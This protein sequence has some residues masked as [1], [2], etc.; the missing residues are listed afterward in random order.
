M[1]W[2]SLRWLWVSLVVTVALA[3][4]L[5][6]AGGWR[7]G[8]VFAL[9][10]LLPGIAWR[11]RLP[12]RRWMSGL[13]L[14]L[15]LVTWLTLL[16]VYLPGPLSRAA[17]AAGAALLALLPLALPAGEQER[18]PAP[19]DR[20]LLLAVAAVLL[21]AAL[22]RLPNMGA[23][24]LQGDE[25]IV[26]QRAA[27]AMLGDDAQL[28]RHQKGPV[29]ILI[30]LA[31]WRLNGLLDETTARLPFTLAGLLVIPALMLAA[32]GWLP[33][34]AAV[35]A[36]LFLALNGFGVAFARIVQYQSFV[37]LWGVLALYHA[38][39]Y[40]QGRLPGDLLLA[41]AFLGGG[42][43]AHYDAILLAPAVAW[44]V[45]PVLFRQG[46][47][48]W[49]AWAT[50]LL[51][52]AL[53][54]GSF[55]LPYALS[56]TFGGTSSYLLEDRLGNG[57][58]W[59]GGRVW[60]M[61]TLYNDT[62]M[63]VALLLLAAVGLWAL[64]REPAALLLFAVPALFYTVVV[65]DPRTHIYTAAP[66]LALLAAAGGLAL[67]RAQRTLAA[68]LLALLAASSTLYLA[69]IF[70]DPTPERQRTWAE[71]APPF[72]L[73]TWDAPPEYGLFGFPHQA[74]WRL[75][76][77]RV[78]AFPYASNEEEEITAWYM[79]QAPRTY[80]PDLATFLRA[81]R[82]QDALPIP[83]EMVEGLHL[84]ETILVNGEPSLAIFGREPAGTPRQSE[85]AGVRLWRAPEEVVPRS[86]EPEHPLD[87]TLGDRVRLLGY[88]LDS[89]AAHPGGSLGVTLYWQALAPFER[90]YQVFVHLYDGQMRAQDDGAPRCDTHPTTHWEP[91]DI[92][93]DPRRLAL[94]ADLPPG[95]YPLLAGMYDLLEGTRLPIA[96]TEGDALP[97][98][99]VTIRDEAQ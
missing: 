82:A 54:A 11:T 95:S 84:Q 35:V 31:T 29:E 72:Y 22:L 46:R 9:L 93:A 12:G 87:V 74:G 56:P 80:C 17:L 40:R 92:I 94:P 34:G 68:L 57:L 91:V 52:G 15:L 64:R 32:R 3:S 89:S 16:L 77:R 39:R 27:A 48:V 4:V 61:A 51:A 71:N 33:A 79:A 10:W 63:V 25:G 65:V 85:A 81:E 60:Q 42:L 24:E 13:G 43:L 18:E 67:W 98:A 23:K 26:L 62:Y 86:P 69:L 76:A 99:Q 47:K 7:Y 96:G 50:A 59:S 5:L 44:L 75:A 30:P 21:L 37:L 70:V 1:K 41:A 66:G 28:L 36:G 20:R 88:D 55:Y 83:P 38:R 73:T 14:G 19:A 78:T 58:S 90:N 97:L 8:P 45:L 6:P 49:R 53:V 2:N